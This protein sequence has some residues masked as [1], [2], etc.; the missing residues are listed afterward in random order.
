MDLLNIN[1]AD[2]RERQVCPIKNAF[3]E[4]EHGCYMLVNEDGTKHHVYTHLR[5]VLTRDAETLPTVLG[6]D[7]C[8]VL[9]AYSKLEGF[10]A[11]TRVSNDFQGIECLA[12]RPE[13]LRAFIQDAFKNYHS[14]VRP[15]L[16]DKAGTQYDI[17]VQEM[18]DLARSEGMYI[19]LR[20]FNLAPS[21]GAFILDQRLAFFEMLKLYDLR[22]QRLE[23]DGQVEKPTLNMRDAQTCSAASFRNPRS[24][25]PELKC[26]Y[27]NAMSCE[28]IS[29]HIDISGKTL[30]IHPPKLC[31]FLL[32]KMIEDHGEQ[33]VNHTLGFKCKFVT[34]D[35]TSRLPHRF[36]EV[37]G[38]CTRMHRLCL[39]D[40]YIG[41]DWY[42]W[43]LEKIICLADVKV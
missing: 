10:R 31:E 6:Y 37:F 40:E 3:H 36:V 14:Y 27:Q 21:F 12:D 33:Q 32:D 38:R 34:A 39:P 5:V 11:S 30:L 29:S 24:T 22:R 15:L 17:C 19:A 23:D 26:Q 35:P 13:T 25:P 20:P 18:F 41:R 43:L 1:D 16:V 4:S 8:Y 42:N 7:Q 28:H 9:E 2:L